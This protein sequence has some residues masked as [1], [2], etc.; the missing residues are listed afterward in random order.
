MNLHDSSNDTILSAPAVRRDFVESAASLVG[1]FN[2]R[3]LDPPTFLEAIQ[4][5]I[6]GI[7]VKLDLA[8]GARMDQL[9]QLIS[10]PG[11]GVEQ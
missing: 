1:L 11:S 4:Q 2:P 5:G 6:E 9:T 8:A 10:M 3:P 7:D